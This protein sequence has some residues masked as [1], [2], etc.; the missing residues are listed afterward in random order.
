MISSNA[1][2]NKKIDAVH[3]F[4]CTVIYAAFFYIEIVGQLVTV[5]AE[6]PV[7]NRVSTQCCTPAYLHD[8]VCGIAHLRLT[9]QRN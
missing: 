4:L 3:E 1:V 7:L 9:A 5:I 8:P 2:K 6:S